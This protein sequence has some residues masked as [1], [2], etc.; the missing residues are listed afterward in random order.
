MAQLSKSWKPELTELE[1][2]MNQAD[3]SDQNYADQVAGQAL[4]SANSYADT[5]KAEAISAANSYADTKKAEAISSANSYAD[6]NKAARQNS[7][8]SSSGDMS[9]GSWQPSWNEVYNLRLTN[10]NNA[11][12]FY[13]G[14]VTNDYRAGVQVGHSSPSYA[15]VYGTMELNPFGGT[16]R[17]NGNS[18]YHTGNMTL[19]EDKAAGAVGTYAMLYNGS[20]SSLIVKGQTRAGSDLEWA[21]AAG[22]REGGVPVETASGTWRCMGYSSNTSGAENKTT[23]WLRIA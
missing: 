15:G 12:I 17:I 4:T 9:F 2:Q 3:Q 5:K 18:A 1:Q 6:S 13:V 8:I 14:G 21:N 11:M 10:A 7:S 23:L 16:V 20:A 19:P 22:L